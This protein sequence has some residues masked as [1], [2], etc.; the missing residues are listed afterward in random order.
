MSPAARDISSLAVGT[1]WARQEGRHVMAE[2][3][4]AVISLVP[5]LAW[6]VLAGPLVTG[7]PAAL[8]VRA[9]TGVPPG[10]WLRASF[11]AALGAL[12][13]RAFASGTLG[14]VSLRRRA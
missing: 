7:T 14:S 2:A 5:V 12:A 4:D 11:G 1:W 6:A 9:A 13:F 10:A 3:H 8:P